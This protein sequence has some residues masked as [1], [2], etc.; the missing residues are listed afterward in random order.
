MH[1]SSFETFLTIVE[2]G[3]LVRASEQLHVTQSTVTARLQAL[4]SQ[5]GQTLLHRQKNG[6]HLTAAGT[7]FR[8]YAAAMTELWRQARLET[9][10]PEGMESVCNLGCDI[11]L[12]PW[13]G[14]SFCRDVRE[15][16]PTVALSAWP[17]DPGEVDQW[18]NTG[19]IDVGLTH[20]ATA[21]GKQTVHPL[22]NQRILLYSTDPD[23][24]LRFDPDYVFVDHGE[25]FG[26]RHAA[27]YSDA[28]TAKVTFGSAVWALDYVLE[29]GGS[30]Y[31]PETLAEPHHA[32]GALHRIDG[33]P[34]F[35]RR[36]YLIVN[37]AA[38][39]EWSWLPDLIQSLS[40]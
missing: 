34:E 23:A 22:V 11:D 38:A 25:E 1:L 16:H 8:R 14:A 2:T 28:D 29:R 40:R 4:E 5:L 6:V 37:D 13:L 39:A 10:L 26:R 27:A 9:S 24:P 12:W 15:C 31:L 20:R 30:A 36:A 17:A 32:A 3:S 21:R 35:S 33:A 19:L 7:R 18:L